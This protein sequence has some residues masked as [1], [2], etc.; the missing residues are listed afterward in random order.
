M[1]YTVKST[2]APVKL[3]I[4]NALLKLLPSTYSE[5]NSSLAM[6]PPVVVAVVVPVTV[7]LATE[8]FLSSSLVMI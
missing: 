3:A 1:E 7:A 5:K 4:S 6:D 8:E 2:A